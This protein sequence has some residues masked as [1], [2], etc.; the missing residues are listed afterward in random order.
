MGCNIIQTDTYFKEAK[1]IVKKHP[2]VL[3]RYIKT[4]EILEVDPIPPSLRLHKLQG[5][6]ECYYSVSSNKNYRVVID[7]VLTEKEIIP[8]DIGAHDEVY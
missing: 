8:I 2:D 5:K 6:L 1:K 4:V 3:D 7:F